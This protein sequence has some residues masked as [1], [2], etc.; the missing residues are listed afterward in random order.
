MD[1]LGRA[2]AALAHVDLHVEADAG[3]VAEQGI[4][5]ARVAAALVADAAGER[6]AH[7]LLVAGTAEALAGRDVVAL[8]LAGDSAD[9]ENGEEESGDLHCFGNVP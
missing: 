4:R 8:A 9:Q 7:A 6:K 3:N 2:V 5:L 1:L